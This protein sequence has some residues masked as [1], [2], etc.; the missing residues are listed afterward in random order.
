M[1]IDRYLSLLGP[2]I[3]SVPVPDY[4]AYLSF[5]LRGVAAADPSLD[6]DSY[7]TSLGRKIVRQAETLCYQ[8]MVE[9]TEGVGVGQMLS[10][11]LNQGPLMAAVRRIQVVPTTGYDAPVLIQQGVVD[12]TA[13]GPLTEIFVH[14]ATTGGADIDYRRLLKGHRILD[15]GSGIAAG[16]AAGKLR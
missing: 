7:L 15:E 4:I 14:D 6:I 12:V 13:F 8:D 16:W 3:P 9:A 5:V 2:Q 1:H 10:R 11:P